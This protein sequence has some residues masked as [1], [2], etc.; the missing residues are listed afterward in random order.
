MIKVPALST[1]RDHGALGNQPSYRPTLFSLISGWALAETNSTN[2]RERYAALATQESIER[3]SAIT[4]KVAN[5]ERSV[6]FCRDLLG[7]K[8]LYGCGAD[9]GFT[10]L[11]APGAEF[12][13]LNLQFAVP[14]VGWGPDD[15]SPLRR[16]CILE[17]SQRER[18]Q[19]RQS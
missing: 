12:P 17:P 5:M 3:I 16:G 9:A 13:I 18:T 1:H 6:R 10:S 2:A 7:L 11:R 19:S 4:L 15:F 14:G 8:R